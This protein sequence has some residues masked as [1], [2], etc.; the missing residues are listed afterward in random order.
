MQQKID[1]AKKIIAQVDVL[2]KTD[3][4]LKEAVLNKLQELMPDISSRC[5][6]G[7]GLRNDINDML[8]AW[9]IFHEKRQIFAEY[10]HNVWEITDI[11][12]LHE[13]VGNVIKYIPALRNVMRYRNLYNEVSALSGIQFADVVE[14]VTGVANW[15]EFYDRIFFKNM[16]D[17]ILEHSPLL[18]QFS[19]ATQNE[20]I[21]KFG[22]FD[23]K[24]MT[25]TK[26]L[27]FAR[28]A[29]NLPR[30]RSDPRPAAGQSC[31][32]SNMSVK[33]AQDICR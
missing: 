1:Q 7:S 8:E 20:R 19:G 4:Q 30:R 3:R 18:C 10:S 2:A 32:F 13:K 12:A 25:L 27:I 33:N 9:N 14:K 31:S 29:A 28:L 5:Q 21:K 6:H 24:Y 22:E 17:Q 23:A 11:T 15:E 26:K 16:L